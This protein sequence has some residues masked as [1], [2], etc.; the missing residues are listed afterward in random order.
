MLS[1]AFHTKCSDLNKFPLSTFN[2][3][4]EELDCAH[5]CS[6]LQ[7]LSGDCNAYTF[8]KAQETCRMASLPFLED[9]AIGE[10]AQVR[11]IINNKLTIEVIYICIHL[12]SYPFKDIQPSYW[13]LLK[14]LS[15]H[16]LRRVDFFK[17]MTL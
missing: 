11:Q 6:F 14:I 3:Y 9:P 15:S 5:Q 7:E 12:Q 4:A 2:S 13:L 8:D 17:W 10:I 16:W 1:I